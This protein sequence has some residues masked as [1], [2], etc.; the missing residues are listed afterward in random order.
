MANKKISQLTAAAPLTGT[1][2]LPIVQDG[3]TVQ[4]TAQDVADLA[5]APYLV[6]TA[7]L[8]Q[9]ETNDPT[10]NVLQN[11]MTSPV[12]IVRFGQGIYDVSC[13][14]FNFFT[15]NKTAVSPISANSSLLIARITINN[16][17]TFRIQT[18]TSNSFL[19]SNDNCLGN[20]MIEVRVYP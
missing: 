19:V 1:E 14:D 3:V 15:L 8:S 10:V 6:F 16:P 13:N 12:T 9:S 18:F 7:L 4:T 2:L 5:G 17:T 20:S 11:T